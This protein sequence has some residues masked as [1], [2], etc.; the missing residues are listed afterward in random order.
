M[1]VS[2]KKAAKIILPVDYCGSC[3]GAET[4]ERRLVL[5]FERCE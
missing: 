3:Y 4:P 2:Q 1:I 5:I